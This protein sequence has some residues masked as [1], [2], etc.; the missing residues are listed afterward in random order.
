LASVELHDDEHH[1]VDTT[2]SSTSTP[3]PPA[4]TIPTDDIS[5]GETDGVLVEKTPPFR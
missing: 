4:S 1:D 5:G 2:T 3:I